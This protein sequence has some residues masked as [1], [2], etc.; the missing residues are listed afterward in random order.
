MEMTSDGA[1]LWH[2]FKILERPSE[3]LGTALIENLLYRQL[4]RTLSKKEMSKREGL[5]GAL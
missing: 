3:T 5:Q 4:L 2:P 1:A